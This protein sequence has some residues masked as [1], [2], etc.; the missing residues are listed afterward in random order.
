MQNVYCF[1]K[2]YLYYQENN[3]IYSFNLETQETIKIR[4]VPKINLLLKSEKYLIFSDNNKVYI[5]DHCYHS[6]HT[7]IQKIYLDSEQRNIFS[8][9]QEKILQ[10]NIETEN[11][12]LICYIDNF[13]DMKITKTKIYILTENEVIFYDRITDK[14]FDMVYCLNR[15]YKFIGYTFKIENKVENREHDIFPEVKVPHKKVAM[16]QIKGVN[17]ENNIAFLRRNTVLFF[18]NENQ[19][20]NIFNFKE[21]ILNAFVK[22]NNLIT[23][24]N[25]F[26][27]RKNLTQK[28]DL[29]EIKENSLY[30]VLSIEVILNQSELEH[31][32]YFENCFYIQNIDQIYIFEQSGALRKVLK[33]NFMDICDNKIVTEFNKLETK[34]ICSFNK[35]LYVLKND[36]IYCD[37]KLILAGQFNTFFVDDDKILVADDKQLKIIDKNEVEIDI[38]VKEIIS[39]KLIVDNNGDYQ[40]IN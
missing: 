24:T 26:T 2:N 3:F 29:Y 18:D 30:Y 20:S 11:K 4:E 17:S 16:S 39:T 6:H 25:K 12:R 9:C 34:K 5:N 23:V 21:N 35:K 40:L 31:I 14:I 27:R 22:N 15:N 37:E 10:Y 8:V 38:C 28:V 33:S 7:K 1:Y 36:G 19:I 32:I 13:I